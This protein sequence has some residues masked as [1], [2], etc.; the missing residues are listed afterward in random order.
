MN[1][2]VLNKEFKKQLKNIIYLCKLKHRVLLN[3][4][5]E[6]AEQWNFTQKM[7]IELLRV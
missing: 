1:V 5:G 6:I 3:L 2:G 7:L 4:F